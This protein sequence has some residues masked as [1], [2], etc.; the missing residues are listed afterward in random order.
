VVAQFQL[1]PN[2]DQTANVGLSWYVQNGDPNDVTH[3][4]TLTPTGIN[5]D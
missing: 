5:V 4:F 3:Y 2:H 1:D